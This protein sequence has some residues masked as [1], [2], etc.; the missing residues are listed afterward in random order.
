M[1]LSLLR[2]D[3][4]LGYEKDLV[5]QQDPNGNVY[6]RTPEKNEWAPS[7]IIRYE[8]IIVLI[9]VL[10]ILLFVFKRIFL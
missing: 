9:I 2:K 4:L 5:L 1:P 10:I 7:T 3:W 8:K 6:W